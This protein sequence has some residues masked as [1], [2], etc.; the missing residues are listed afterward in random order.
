MNESKR[1][2]YW[3]KWCLRLLVVVFAG[4]LLA[5]ARQASIASEVP[6]GWSVSGISDSSNIGNLVEINSLLLYY[7][8]FEEKAQRSA[9]S[10]AIIYRKFLLVA[11]QEL[12][13]KLHL[14]DAERL[15]RRDFV[16]SSDLEQ[17]VA[18]GR[19]VG[20][21]AV[22]TPIFFNYQERIGS[23]LGA[24]VPA[25][26]DFVVRVYRVRDA[27]MIWEH[28]YQYVD[29]AMSENIFSLGDRFKRG[30]G[31]G[32]ANLDDLL[33]QGIESAC[34]EFSQNRSEQFLKRSY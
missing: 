3:Q 33:V 18:L 9:G 29:R 17:I 5:C 25:S 16:V 34:K 30:G 22:M 27:S 4:S 26:I 24:S 12:G 10:A 6:R 8:Q 23:A 31:A 7:P 32:W 11:R 21:D 28:T 15:N 19:D 14:L 2:T 13:L 1:E 20:A